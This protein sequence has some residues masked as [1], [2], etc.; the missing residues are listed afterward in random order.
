MNILSGIY[1]FC[2]GEHEQENIVGVKRVAE[3][4]PSRNNSQQLLREH[5]TLLE[6]ETETL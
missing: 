4:K 3:M 2:Q 5:K 1:I 6:L